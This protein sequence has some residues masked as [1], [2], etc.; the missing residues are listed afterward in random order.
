MK[1]GIKITLFGNVHSQT[2]NEAD[3]LSVLQAMNNDSFKATF[4]E[5]RSLYHTDKDEYKRRKALL[6]AFTPSGLFRKKAASTLV[7]PTGYIGVDFDAGDNPHITD[8][9]KQRDEIA[10]IKNI[11]YCALSA[12]GNGIFC[13]VKT[14]ADPKKHK[15]HFNALVLCFKNLGINVDVKCG[16]INRMR[17]ITRDLNAILKEEDPVPFTQTLDY[18]PTNKPIIEQKPTFTSKPKHQRRRP[19][20][21]AKDTQ[22]QVEELIEKLE[23][24][25]IDITDGYENWL[26]IGFAL[27]HEFGEE[28]R[29][30][31]HSI[32]QF[33]PAYA[34]SR[35]NSQYTHCLNA[36]E[37]GNPVTIST[38]FYIAKDFGVL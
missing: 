11:D 2:A 31:Y 19:N 30:Y 4:D 33:N 13:M 7:K 9:A 37:S 18:K 5:L 1:A 14:T 24:D 25:S 23:A 8:F 38:L 21:K 16:N 12:S 26:K 6:P 20:K 32:S 3:L 15:Q 34:E 17:F 36:Q 22:T 35:T 27:A 29:E 10:K 28:G